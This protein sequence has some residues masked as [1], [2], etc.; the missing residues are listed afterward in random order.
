[1]IR[2]TSP[3]GIDVMKVFEGC[4]LVAYRDASPERIWTIGRGHTGAG[5]TQGLRIDQVRADQLFACDLLSFETAVCSA[6]HVELT[7]GQ[8]DA[9]VSF[10]Y[11]C[12]GWRTSDLIRLVNA[13]DFNGAANEFPKWC[14]AGAEILPGLVTRRA[15]E[16]KL[17]SAV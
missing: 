8:F 17:F 4:R 12:K 16:Q 3:A 1:M 5:V 14:H 9:L 2:R 13:R 6:V 10:A 11:N 15:A 7:Q